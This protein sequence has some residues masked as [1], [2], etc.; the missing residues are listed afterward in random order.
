MPLEKARTIFETLQVD[1]KYWNLSPDGTRL[2]K[3]VY[4]NDYY[5]AGRIIDEILTI[6]RQE[7]RNTPSF[8]LLNGDLL[9]IELV[10][11]SIQGLS[12]V[13]FELALKLNSVDFERFGGW[14]LPTDRNYRTE[15]RMR[16][17]E[18]AN[19]RVMEEIRQQKG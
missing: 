12:S 3:W 16:K 11:P 8:A 1:L 7:T 9:K 15:V 5:Q 13:D 10:S 19:R 18:M 4:L 2:V 17:N 6:D 14:E